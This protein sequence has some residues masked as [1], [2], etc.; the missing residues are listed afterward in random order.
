VSVLDDIRE[1]Q[2]RVE[3]DALAGLLARFGWNLSRVAR[4][5]GVSLGCVQYRV[6]KHPSLAEEVRL[7]GPGVGRPRNL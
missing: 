5:L 2:E 6:V 4:H 7:R 3:R 1:T